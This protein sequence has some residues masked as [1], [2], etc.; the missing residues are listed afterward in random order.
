MRKIF[1]VL[2]LFILFIGSDLLF[3]EAIVI[4]KGSRANP[5][6][7]LAAS[8][9]DNDLKNEITRMLRVAN[10]FDLVSS[11]AGDFIL[12][13]GGNSYGL[14]YRL[15]SGGAVKASGKV[16]GN[17]DNNRC[18]KI[19]VD[20]ILKKVFKVP[21]LCQSKIVF[22]VGKT[23]SNR[24]IAMSDI[25]GRN[26]EQITRFKGLAVEPAFA[27]NG[28][29]VVY[30]S[31][32]KN[33][34]SILETVIYPRGSRKLSSFSGL[35]TGAAISPDGRYLAM[36]LSKDKQVDLYLRDMTS[37]RLVR[38]T[39]D[40]AVE[41]SPCFSP[42]GKFI[43]FLSDKSGRPKLY[44][45]NVN[46]SQLK[47]LPSVGREALTP[48]WS[49]D[50]KIAYTTRIDSEYRIAILDITTGRN[51]LVPNLTGRW[52]SPSWA[53]DN[54]HLVCS[55]SDSPMR[56]SLYIIDSWTGKCRKLFNSQNYFSTP[57][58]SKVAIY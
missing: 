50:N 11:G 24:N 30:S 12:E 17:G 45:V 21:V 42:D 15:V 19:L 32:G 25:D 31:Y 34:I 9:V 40:K 41:S 54:R 6:L 43:C 22:S 2:L 26:F 44:M 37:K 27:P 38:L 1:S 53:P 55:K 18:A 8:S 51:E 46:G 13:L 33:N 7:V 47:L 36:I 39:G 48:D 35:N 16:M 23:M 28:K 49:Q 4:K 57:N 10:W 29:S 5:T 56:S 58:W 3:A 14:S 20:D 52:E